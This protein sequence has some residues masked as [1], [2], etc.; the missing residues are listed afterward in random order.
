MKKTKPPS[1]KKSEEYEKFER[2]AKTLLAVPKSE[3]DKREA[4]YQ[5]A[6]KSAKKPKAA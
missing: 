2:F 4:A 1:S 6:K 3:I 5:K